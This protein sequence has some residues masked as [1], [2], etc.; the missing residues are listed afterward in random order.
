MIP[1]S[2]AH[3]NEPTDPVQ[4][5][6]TDNNNNVGDS[7]ADIQARDAQPIS[8]THI[9]RVMSRVVE[10]RSKTHLILR[11]I[12]ELRRKQVVSRSYK[13][14]RKTEHGARRFFYSN[15]NKNNN[16]NVIA[17]TPDVDVDERDHARSTPER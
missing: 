15:N 1:D 3:D 9:G 13:K 5:T 17:A 8:M 16:D 2:D 6:S 14:I 10:G 4:Q 11:P 12:K 7:D